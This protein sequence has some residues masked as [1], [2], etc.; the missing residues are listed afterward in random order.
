MSSDQA[1]V[2]AYAGR[3][4][5]LVGASL[6]GVTSFYT[7]GLGEA[8]SAT[9]LILVDIVLRPNVAGAQRIAQFMRAHLDG[10]ASLSEAADA[11]AAY[12]PFRP[13]PVDSNRLRKNLRPRSNGRLYWH[14]DPRFIENF[15]PVDPPI[16]SEELASVSG[17]VRVPTLLV[18]GAESDM[19][20]DDG[21]AELQCLVPQTGSSHRFK[22]RTHDRRRCQRRIQRR[23]D[24]FPSPVSSRPH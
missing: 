12:K 2:L 16:L 11:V 7:V 18:R 22:S 9:A 1:A 5:A 6:G 17:G 13:R 10:F 4:V 19:V 3:P 8:P 14:W 23:G 15:P 20:A 24:R 21:V